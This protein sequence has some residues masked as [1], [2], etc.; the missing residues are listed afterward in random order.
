VTSIDEEWEEVLADQ[1]GADDPPPDEPPDDDHAGEYAPPE[2]SDLDRYAGFWEARPAFRYI[3]DFAYARMCSPWAVLGVSI[4]CVLHHVPPWVTLPPLI[5]DVG[6][7]NVITALVGP[8]GA[9]KSAAYR[10][11]R[12][13]FDLHQE[14]IY[15]APL[16]SGE[17]I[18]RQ[19][20]SAEDKPNDRNQVI[21]YAAEIDSVASLVARNGSTLSGQLR[22]AFSGEDLGFAYRNDKTRL[23]VKEN[24]YRFGLVAGIQPERARWLIDQSDG[25]TPQ[26]LV[27]FPVFD[28]GI[29]AEP[30]D[31]PAQMKIEATRRS[32]KSGPITLPDQVAREIR[33]AHA[34]RQR[35]DSEALDGHVMYCREKVAYALTLLDDRREMDLWDW[36]LSATIM[37]KSDQVRASVISTLQRQARLQETARAVGEG[38]RDAIKGQMAREDELQRACQ[39]I[40]RKLGRERDWVTGNEARHAIPTPLRHLFDEV[41]DKLEE[42]GQVEVEN[43]DHHGQKGMRVRLES[44]AR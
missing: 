18:A 27:W 3:R 17:G 1:A 11:G 42:T 4:V 15:T 24:T 37:G 9:A 33:E 29:T 44:G 10:A 32:W 25:G 13:A 28:L 30:P 36:E 12:R 16:G 39:A 7:F 26:R 34:A 5:G 41:I 35:G 2:I 43:L 19:Y 6:N 22:S 14:P 40:T 21:F 31:E 8:S 38:R 23:I 20:K